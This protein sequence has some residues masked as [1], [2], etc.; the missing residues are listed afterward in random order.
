MWKIS[1]EPNERITVYINVWTIKTTYKWDTYVHTMKKVSILSNVSP[2]QR[3][4]IA[5]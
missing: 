2:P 3:R 1:D 5:F 4:G